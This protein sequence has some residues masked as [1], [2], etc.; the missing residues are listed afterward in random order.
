MGMGM[1]YDVEEKLIFLGDSNVQYLFGAV[2]VC[3]LEEQKE[4]LWFWKR[5]G[6]GN[7][8]KVLREDDFLLETKPQFKGVWDSIIPSNVAL[9][10]WRVQTTHNLLKRNII[11][12]Q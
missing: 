10:A 6:S 4:D 1:E 5:C 8:Y 3:Q 7:A 2:Q 12:Q 11:H 9:S